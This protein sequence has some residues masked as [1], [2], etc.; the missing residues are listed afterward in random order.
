[1]SLGSQGLHFLA[2]P[3]ITRLYSPADFG[4]L[5][6]FCSVLNCLGPAVAVGYE[7]AI[8]VEEAEDQAVHVLRLCLSL[9]L[10]STSGI[11]LFLWLGRDWLLSWKSLQPLGPYLHLLALAH[12]SVGLLTIFDFWSLRQR[13]Y[14]AQG[15]TKIVQVISQ[16]AVQLG[17][18]HLQFSAL[19]LIA[20]QI[21]GST[22]GALGLGRLALTSRSKWD[23]SAIVVALKK[24]KRYPLLSSWSSLFK[25]F[26][27][28]GPLLLLAYS[29]GE[30]VAGWFALSQRVI[31]APSAVFGDALCRVFLGEAAIAA[32]GKGNLRQVFFRAARSQFMVGAL[33][34]LPIGFIS[35]WLFPKLFGQR[36]ATAG[37]YT[38]SLSL[39][40]LALFV[41]A[42]MEQMVLLLERQDLFAVQE[43][44]RMAL[45]LAPILLVVAKQGSPEA[46]ILGMSVGGIAVAI[47][48][49]AI[50]YYSVVMHPKR[51]QTALGA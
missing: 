7:V 18:G 32:R 3:I 37:Q 40:N 4:V 30:T 41:S 20:G 48:N 39:M 9:L 42:P 45:I 12:L 8:L 49:S 47:I 14:M 23:W 43:T 44:L 34:I 10:V 29:Y 50:A 19:G 38:A 28:Q 46:A 6:V 16:I 26:A 1:M 24:H 27:S 15:C 35:P 17:L 2:S 51:K 22:V 36:W 13:N 11:A 21:M 5:G 33:V 31:V 25:L